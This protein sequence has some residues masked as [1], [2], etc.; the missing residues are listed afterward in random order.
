M[1]HLAVL[2][3]I[4]KDQG[5][6]DRVIGIAHR[7]LEQAHQFVKDHVQHILE[8]GIFI[9]IMA[10]KRGVADFGAVGNV[11]NGDRFIA[12]LQGER[13]QRPGQRFL[14]TPDPAILHIHNE[15]LQ[16]LLGMDGCYPFLYCCN[17]SPPHESLRQLTTSQ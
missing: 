7:R 2:L 14:R 16:L 9:T 8:Q 13:D 5:A 10:E 1:D 11:T 15:T 4:A 12:F 6:G 3:N 17:V